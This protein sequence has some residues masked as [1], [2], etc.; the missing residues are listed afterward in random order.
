MQS[1]MFML[2]NVED[3]ELFSHAKQELWI[4]NNN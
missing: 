2:S 4:M 3:I 1:Q